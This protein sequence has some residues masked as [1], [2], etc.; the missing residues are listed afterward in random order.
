MS[1]TECSAFSYDGKYFG[2]CGDDGKLKIW[3]TDT[4]TLKKEYIPNLHLSE[5]CTCLTWLLNINHSFLV[6]GKSGPR[7]AR[8]LFVNKRPQ[9]S[10]LGTLTHLGGSLPVFGATRVRTPVLEGYC[11]SAGYRGSSTV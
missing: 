6:G 5:P 2:Y 7:H 10:P 9:H 8:T 3:E 11:S 1:S 4:G